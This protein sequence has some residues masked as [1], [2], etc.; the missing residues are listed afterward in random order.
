MLSRYPMPAGTALV[1]TLVLAACAAPHGSS[2]AAPAGGDDAR[3]LDALADE[4]FA[5]LVQTYPSF[6]LFSGIPDA[7]LDRLDPNSLPDVRRW[8]AR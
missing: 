6:G 2:G 8:Q 7:P 4:Y 1:I 3:R 5:A